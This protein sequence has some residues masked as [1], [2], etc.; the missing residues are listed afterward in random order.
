[1]DLLGFLAFVGV[2]GLL[3]LNIRLEGRIEKL[4]EK[5]GINNDEG[6]R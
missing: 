5:L 2:V 3:V 4:E 1:M 6:D